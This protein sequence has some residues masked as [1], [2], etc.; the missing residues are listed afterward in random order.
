MIAITWFVTA[1]CLLGNVL[2]AKKYKVSFLVWIACNIFWAVY[3]FNNG[4]YS[5]VFMSLIQTLICIYGYFK[6]E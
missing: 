6:W 4:L 2:N 1:L 5:R 3:D